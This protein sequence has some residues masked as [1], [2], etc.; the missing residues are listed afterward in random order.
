MKK[1]KYFYLQDRNGRYLNSI[2]FFKKRMILQNTTKK[3]HSIVYTEEDCDALRS[4][5]LEKN[6]V[7][8]PVEMDFKTNDE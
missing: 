2:R 1:V 7:C 8:F 4:F 6:I 5:Y 3:S